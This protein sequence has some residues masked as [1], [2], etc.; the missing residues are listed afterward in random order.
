MAGEETQ[1]SFWNNW[2]NSA[3]P[4]SGSTVSNVQGPYAGFK[5]ETT[6]SISADPFAIELLNA[7]A[8]VIKA[9][10]ALLRAR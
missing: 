9:T 10:A 7:P 4:S 1:G 5:G 2:K 8:S 6:T 3:L